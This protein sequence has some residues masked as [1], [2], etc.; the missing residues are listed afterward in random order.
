MSSIT[1]DVVHE[2]GLPENAQW[3]DTGCSLHSACLTCPFDKCRYDM[4]EDE[5]LALGRAVRGGTSYIEERSEER[6]KRVLALR[7]QGVKVDEI[8]EMLHC[9]RRTVFRLAS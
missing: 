4:T 7:A 2:L 8:A 3:R 5:R 9:T 6:R 1:L